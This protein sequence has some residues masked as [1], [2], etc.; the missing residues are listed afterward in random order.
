MNGNA[1]LMQPLAWTALAASNTAPGF[2]AGNLGIDRM[3]LVWR[4]DVG[5]AT[6]SLTIDMG[7][8]VP[9]NMIALFGIGAGNAAPGA[10]WQWSIDLATQAQG[11]FGGAFWAGT[12]EGLMAGSALP[13]SGRGKALWLAPADAP[14]AA[15]HIR[16]NLSALGTAAVQIAYAAVGTQIQFER[17]FSFGAA[18][19]V[20]A[21]GTVD[22]N[23]RGVM[24][25][26]RGAR[27]R[28]VGLS[29]GSV[30]RDE[31]EEQVQ[32][33]IERVGNDLPLVLVT[34]PAA[35]AQ[36]QGRMYLGFLT[37]NLGSVWARPGGF[38]ADINLVAID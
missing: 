30:R 7:A 33:L 2:A 12:V 8:D 24:R 23:A 9:V 21:L 28:G 11:A 20:R 32:R 15:R 22:W 29:F 5:S 34:D 18:F 4:S 25:R 37:G 16:I 6:R 1:I 36:R 35:H 14:A 19:G 17:N 38:R 10:G 27:L 13:E 3:G 31:L 26:R